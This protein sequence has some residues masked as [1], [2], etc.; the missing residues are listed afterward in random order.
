MSRIIPG[1]RYVQRVPDLSKPGS[2]FLVWYN[3]GDAPEYGPALPE[4]RAVVDNLSDLY[5]VMEIVYEYK[6]QWLSSA[7]TEDEYDRI[8]AFDANEI[9][10]TLTVLAPLRVRCT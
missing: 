9:K 6:A 3:V 2:S 5:H 1:Y 7:A 8:K 10:R 4:L